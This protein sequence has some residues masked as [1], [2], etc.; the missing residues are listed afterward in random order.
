MKQSRYIIFA[1]P[2]QDSIEGLFEVE[3]GYTYLQDA[4]DAANNLDY[5]CEKIEIVDAQNDWNIVWRFP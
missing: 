2:I 5:H 4:I 3:R 1:W